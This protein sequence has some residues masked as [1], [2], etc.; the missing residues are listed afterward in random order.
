MRNRRN[1]ITVAIASL[2]LAMLGNGFGEAFAQSAS[3][4]GSGLGYTPPGYSADISKPVENGAAQTSVSESSDTDAKVTQS[5]N[6]EWKAYCAPIRECIEGDTIIP[7]KNNKLL[8]YLFN[9]DSDTNVTLSIL[10]WKKNK[11]LVQFKEGTL[12]KSCALNQR[13]LR[14]MMSALLNSGAFDPNSEFAQSLTGSCN[15]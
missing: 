8:S 4:G 11:C 1:R 3:G 6:S 13:V 12:V 14:E 9:N 7:S 10:G 5:C 2:L 15:G